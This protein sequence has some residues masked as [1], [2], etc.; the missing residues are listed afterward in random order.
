MNRHTTQRTEKVYYIV[1]LQLYEKMQ[2]TK[3][4]VNTRIKEK[5]L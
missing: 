3:E 2:Q 5:T 1:P 4:F